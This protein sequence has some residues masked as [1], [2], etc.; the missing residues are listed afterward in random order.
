V[1][2]QT[3]QIFSSLAGQYL[4]PALSEHNGHVA[5]A[6][7]VCNNRWSIATGLGV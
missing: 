1:P 5:M 2:Q 7:E 3:A 4:F 6:V